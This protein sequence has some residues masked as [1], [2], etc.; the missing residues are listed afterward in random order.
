MDVRRCMQDIRPETYLT[1]A[2]LHRHQPFID[3]KR[4]NTAG[5]IPT[6]PRKIQLG[7]TDR[8]LDEGVVDIDARSLGLGD[9]SN[10]GRCGG[11]ATDAVQL[12]RI[13]IV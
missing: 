13:C 8:A 10:F 6:V 11:C 2:R 5:N 7:H 3:C 12:S 4:S 9:D 1:L